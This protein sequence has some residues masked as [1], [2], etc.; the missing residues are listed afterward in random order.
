MVTKRS[1]TSPPSLQFSLC[2]PFDQKTTKHS[3]ETTD[4]H[5]IPSFYPQSLLQVRTIVKTWEWLAGRRRWPTL[6]SIT[7]SMFCL[8]VAAWS[9]K[10]TIVRLPSYAQDIKYFLKVNSK[11]YCYPSALPLLICCWFDNF[12][13]KMCKNKTPVCKVVSNVYNAG[14]VFNI[15]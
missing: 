7:W 3:D 8:M 1:T 15:I 10:N 6:S 2:Q 9:V 11:L 4:W 14:L 12:P 5:N 13:N